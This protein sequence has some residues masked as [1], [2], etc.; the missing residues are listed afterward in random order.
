MMRSATKDARIHPKLQGAMA[1]DYAVTVTAS[2]IALEPKTLAARLAELVGEPVDEVE[3]AVCRG[4]V[5]LGKELSY[6]EALEVQRALAKRKIPAAISPA[7]AELDGAVVLMGEPPRRGEARRGEGEREEGEREEP[8]RKE[9]EKEEEEGGER[10]SS[11]AWGEL[12]PDLAE[13]SDA[14]GE[15]VEEE[16]EIFEGI[17]SLSLLGGEEE[18]A[19]VLEAVEEL[20]EVEELWEPRDVVEEKA[21]EF[22]A[23]RIHQAF[24][25]ERRAPFE[26]KGYDPR[27]PHVPLIAAIWGVVAPGAGQVYNGQPEKGQ[28]YG[29]TFFLI[30]PWVDGVRQAWARGEKIRTYH[31][32]RPEETA[33]RQA[34]VYAVKW[35]VMVI[36]IAVVAVWVYGAVGDYLEAERQQRERLAFQELLYFGEDVVADAVVEAREEA[37][38]VGEELERKQAK[39]REERARR[40]YIVGYHQCKRGEYDLCAA[41]MRRVTTLSSGN[42]DAR[43][44]QNWA[45]VVAAGQDVELEMPDVG[46]VP[47]LEEFEWE[48]SLEGETLEDVERVAD[49]E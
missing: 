21:Q 28:R 34:V 44:L 10:F 23:G 11:G 49:G 32:P 46:P 37:A 16:G 4:P 38:R 1:R 41:A 22:E 25:E 33:S 8:E 3:A 29:M 27:P 7:G 18:L 15:E 45:S 19:D 30:K 36:V 17:E 20:E 26:P 47:T 42:R 39:E 14:D 43:R 13:M 9:L 40:L 12:F 24:H 6:G 48:L 2:K 31:A 5:I 35:W